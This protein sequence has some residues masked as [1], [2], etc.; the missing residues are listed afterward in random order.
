[1]KKGFRGTEEYDSVSAPYLTMAGGST[2]QA[3]WKDVLT[4]EMPHDSRMEWEESLAR[5]VLAILP[6]ES[7]TE[8]INV[9][10]KTESIAT[11]L[12]DGTWRVKSRS[13]VPSGDSNTTTLGPCNWQYSIQGGSGSCAAEAGQAMRPSC[14]APCAAR[15]SRTTPRR[16]PGSGA[17]SRPGERSGI[18]GRGRGAPSRGRA[19]QQAG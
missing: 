16:A 3:I 5:E 10:I 1:M 15:G 19:P 9:T 8:P 13:E 7:W 2:M 14:A 4:V 11:E 18:P 6:S 17:S 12:G